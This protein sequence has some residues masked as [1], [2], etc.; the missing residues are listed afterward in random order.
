MEPAPRRHINP[1]GP[2]MNG[3]AARHPSLRKIAACLPLLEPDTGKAEGHP[4]GPQV[5][6]MAIDSILVLGALVLAE[7]ARILYYWNWHD[8]P[9]TPSV[10]PPFLPVPL[11]VAICIFVFYVHGFYSYR[12]SSYRKH[13][14]LTIT[15]AVTLAF[16]IIGTVSLLL[17]SLLSLSRGVLVAT[18]LASWA[19]LVGSRLWSDMWRSLIRME[20]S[21]R[22]NAYPLAPPSERTVLVIGGAGYIGS[23]LLP[24][25]LSEGCRVRVLDV[26][27]YGPDPI[28]DVANDPGFELFRG[29]FRQIDVLVKAMRGVDE[30]IHLGGLVGDPACAYDEELTIDINLAATRTIAEVA[31]GNGVRRFIFA[32]TC[33]VYGASDAVLD[34]ASPLNPV[35]LYART[36]IASERVLLELADDLFQP[37][38][39]RFGTI[40][41]ISGRTRFDLV[42]NLLTAKAVLDGEITISGGDQ[43]RPFL[44]VDDA[45]VAIML[46]LTRPLPEDETAPIFNV[47][48]NRENYTIREIGDLVHK[49]VPEANVIHA[50]GDADRRNYRVRFDK[51]ARLGFAPRWRVEDGIKQ[52]L[53]PIVAGEITSYTDSKFSNAKFLSEKGIIHLAPPQA[54]WVYQLLEEQAP[55]WRLPDRRV[56]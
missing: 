11:L 53:A 25:L 27:M 30:V 6:R 10:M 31:K 24:K 50:P 2:G 8:L 21:T 7:A 49:H 16:L 13:K 38:I 28:K 42:V 48:S 22:F 39:I 14:L 29:D 19:L 35:S 45:A 1:L 47:G 34:E 20:E 52:V 15:R 12:H 4:A 18:G 43:W 33:S 40:Y 17:P 37:I 41:G 5:L 23:A 44:H 46:L 51:I 36:K 56:S 32:S 3:A 54:R 55:P 26:M 9:L